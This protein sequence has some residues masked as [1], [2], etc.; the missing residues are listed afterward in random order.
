MHIGQLELQINPFTLRAA[1]R[2]LTI[3]EIFQLQKLLHKNI[4]RR[5]VD[6]KP[7]N[8][9]AWNIFELSLNSQIIFKSMR[10]ADDTIYRNA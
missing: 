5:N 1:K 3:L 7:N 6:Q 10:E 2:G 9:S 4:G 8:N